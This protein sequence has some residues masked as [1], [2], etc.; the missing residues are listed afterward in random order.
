VVIVDNS[1]EDP[2]TIVMSD[3]G[4]GGNLFIPAVLIK[5]EDGQI[6]KK[7]LANPQEAPYVALTLYFSMKHPGNKVKYSIWMSSESPTVRGLVHDMQPKI[8]EFKDG[9]FEFDVHFVL[10]FCPQC[11]DAGYVTDEPDCVSGGRYC[12]PDPDA[13]GPL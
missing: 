2:E 6:I 5:K 3:D 9:A 10:W 4:T 1:D 8:S 7:Y 11:R 12:A 13:E